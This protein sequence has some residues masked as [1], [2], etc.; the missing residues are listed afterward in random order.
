MARMSLEGVYDLHCHSAPDL[1]RGSGTT[2]KSPRCAVRRAWRAGDQGASRMHGVESLLRLTACP[3]HF[4]LWV[5]SSQ[6]LLRGID[7]RS[8][9]AAI[10]SGAKMIWMPTVDAA[11]HA[12]QYGSTGTYGS[13]H[14]SALS[15]QVEG[16]S[17]LDERG[18]LVPEVYSILELIA[19]Y[20]VTVASGISPSR[21]GPVCASCR[22]GRLQEG[23]H[24]PR[25]SLQ[26]HAAVDMMRELI[27]LGAMPEFVTPAFYGVGYFTVEESKQLMDALGPRNCYIA[28]DCGVLRK[29]VL[30]ESTRVFLSCLADLGMEPGDLEVMA[31]ESKKAAGGWRSGHRCRLSLGAPLSAQQVV[32]KA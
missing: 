32:Q 16:I 27:Q 10:R 19:K 29:A 24:H 4:A 23:V 15:R 8:A 7:P 22:R 26:T 1:F 2:L 21:D 6:P 5:G 30:P 11:Y 20:G 31:G 3:W 13:Y 17:I 18:K 9:E 25:Q 14:H 28:S 12:R